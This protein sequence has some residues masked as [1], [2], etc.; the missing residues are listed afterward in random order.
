MAA[1]VS[2]DVKTGRLIKDAEVR[3]IGKGFLISGCLACNRSVKKDDKYVDEAS[4]WNF[5]L[6]GTEKQAEY[7]KNVL[8]KGTQVTAAGSIDQESYT[9][10]EGNKKT[11]Y[12]FNLDRVVP[13]VSGKKDGPSKSDVPS[14]NSDSGFPED[15]PF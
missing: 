11:S 2:Y 15:I 12:V 5:K 13:V 1:D 7:Y 9:D 10:K 3:Q 6:W 8:K 14:Y 4:F